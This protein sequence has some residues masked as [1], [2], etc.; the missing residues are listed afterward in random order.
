MLGKLN[1]VPKR[2]PEQLA[3]ERMLANLALTHEQR[4]VKMMTLIKVS[5]MLQKAE[6]KHKP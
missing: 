2:T 6:I 1:Y 3:H 5:M 4:F